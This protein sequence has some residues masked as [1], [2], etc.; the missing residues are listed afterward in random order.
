MHG[1]L[2][3]LLMFLPHDGVTTDGVEIIER[4]SY[5]DCEGRLI[6]VQAIF[7]ANDNV[8][9]WRLLKGEETI[10]QRPPRMTWS[11]G[12]KVRQVRGRY[13]RETHTQFDPELEAREIL[14]TNQ[15]KGLSK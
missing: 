5:Y 13:W 10:G 9:A 3:I 4:N 14:P 12:D 1:L 6:F 15:R 8:V 7:W 2:L 11:E